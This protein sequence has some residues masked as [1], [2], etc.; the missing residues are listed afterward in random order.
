VEVLTA[1]I[2]VHRLLHGACELLPEGHLPYVG[3]VTVC[4]RIS[5]IEL[6]LRSVMRWVPAPEYML[7]GMQPLVLAGNECS[8]FQGHGAGHAY[9]E[10]GST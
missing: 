1:F 5:L 10:S 3:S 4:M 8:C 2:T 6:L 9:L 7:S